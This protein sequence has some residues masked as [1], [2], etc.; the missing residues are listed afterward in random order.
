MVLT[1][2]GTGDRVSKTLKQE[3]RGG[4]RTGLALLLDQNFFLIERLCWCHSS[5]F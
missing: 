1:G 4:N 5:I 3:R 2:V